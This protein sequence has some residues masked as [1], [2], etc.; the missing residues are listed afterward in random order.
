MAP[1]PS[2]TRKSERLE[3][4]TPTTPAV[5]R[6]SGS[7][8]KQSMSSLLRRSKRGKNQSST[9]SFG[10]KKSGKSLGS[11]VMKKK[12]RKEKS[13]KLLTLETNE[14]GHSEK[15]IIKAVQV[16]TK[17]TDAR[18]YR[19]L[20]KQQQKKA[21]LE[22]FCE[23][24]KNKKAKSSQGYCSNLRAGASENIDGGGDCSQRELSAGG[25]PE[26][27]NNHLD[28][29][30]YLLECWHRGENAVL[31]DDQEQIAKVIYFILSISSNATW[32]FLIIT[33]S[34]ALHSWEE[35]LFRLAPSLYAVVYHGNKDIRKSIRTLEFY[36]EG[37]CI[38]FQILIT[39]PEVIIEDL[40]MLESMKWEAIIVDE[41]QRSRIYSHFKQIKLLSTAMR[42]LLVNGQL[43]VGITEHLLSLLVHQSDPDGSECL[44]IDSSHKTGIFKERLSQYIANGCK[45]DSSR[46]KEYWVPVQ[47][48]IMQLEQYCAI[49]L[50]N[51]LL[52]CSSSKNDLAG[53]LHDIL[54]SAR[55]CCDHPYIMDPSLQISLTKDSKEADI[56]DIGIKASGKLQ[57]LD[58]MLFNIKERGLRVLVL[59]QSSGG[60][61]KDNVGDILDDF[62]SQRFGKGCYELVDGHVLPSR[63]Q[64]A[65]KNFNNLQEGRFV[66]LLETRACSPSIKLSSVDTVII[67]ASDW[68]PHTDIRNLQK[69]TLYSESEQ[70]N[71]FRLYSSCTV[72]ERVLIV[73]RQ[74]KT[75]DRNLQ[76]IN[77]GACHMLLMWGVSYLFD[78][79]SE[80]N[81][82]NDPASSGNMLFEQSHMKDVMQEFLT[83][84]TQKGKDKNLI[85]SIILN[86]KQNQGSYTTNLPLHGEPKIQLLDEELPHVFWERL[87]KGKQPQWKY[88]SGLFQRNRKRVQYFDDIQKN[89][90]VKADEVVKKRKKVAIDNSNSPSLKAAP[91][92]TSGAPVCS[93]SQFMPSSTGCLTTTDANH[94]SNFT[95]L[96]NKLS[97]LPKANAVDYNERMNLH[98]SRKSLHLVLKPEIEKLSEILQLPEDVK[99]MVDQFLEY[100]LNNHHVSREP[101]SVLQAFLISL[102]WT[103][104]SM[105]KYKL[106]RKESLALAEQHLNFRCTKD[107]ADFVYSKL[108]YLKKVFLYHTGNFKLAGSPKAA[109]FSTKDLSTNQ[110]NG[111]PSPSTQSNMQK[112][113][114]EVENLRPSQEFFFDQ[115]LS[116]LGLT[117]KDYSENIEE[118][119]DEQMNKLLQRQREER[120][121][122]K[123]KY[124]EEKAELELIQRTEAAV[125]HLHSNSSMRTD[126]LK[127]LDNVFAKEFKELKRKMEIRLNNVLE[128]Q[129]ATRN[130][131]QER[132]VHWIG[133]KLSGLLNKPLA[134]ESRYDQQNAATLNSCSK[135]QTSERAQSMPD[136]EVLLEALETVSLNE[137]VFSG[138]LS[139]SEPMLDGASSSMLDR[140][141]PL[142]MP[143]SASVS[144]VSE[145]IVYLNASSGEGQ[146]PVTQVAVR[147][148]EAISSSDGPENT[149]HKSSSES[150]NRDALM[151]PDSE[152]PLGV[153][154]IVSSTGGLENAASANPS[155][156]EG[157]TART[158]SCMDGREVLLD[159]PETA[160]LEAEHGNRVMEKDGKSA[161]VS[162][163][164]TEEDQ[165]NG[166]VSMLNQD[167]QSD[168][169]I[170]VNQQN[171]EVLLG[172]PQTNEVGLQDE[173]VPSGVHGTPVE[174]SASNGGENT[175]VYVTAFS[176]GTGVDQLA[177]VLPSG[178]FETATSAE[179]EGSRTQREID[180]IHAVASDTS[181]PAESSRLQDGVAQVCD[182]QIAFQQVDASASQP[183]VVASGQ[184]P[185]DALVTE[186]LLELLLST[187][188]PTPSDSHPATSFAQLSPIDSIAVGGSGMHISN[189]RAAPV[190]P[191]ISN[192]PGTTLA[193]RMPVS[194]S[195]EPLQSELDR[196]SKE[197]EEIIKIHEDTKLQLKSDCEKEIVEV[198]AQIHKKHD[199]KLQEIESDFQCKKKEM[200]DN[201]NKVLMNKILAEAFKTKCMDSRAS[202]TLGKQQEITSSAV[203][204]LLRQSQ[205]TAQRP[206]IVASS[207]VSAD[208]H[209]TSPS[210]SP[211]S[212]PLEVVRCSSLLSGTP[213]RPPHIGSISAITNN[214]QLGSGIRA[215]APHLQPFRPSA[216]ISTTGLSSF[217]HGMQSQ[218]VPSTFPTLSEIPSRAP[219]S[220]QQSGPQTTTNCCESMG[221]SPSS[222]HLPGLDSLMDVG[223]QTIATQPCSF[224]PVTNLISNP[225]QL[226][227]PELSMLHSVNSVLTNPASEV[228]VLFI[229][230]LSLRDLCCLLALDRPFKGSETGL[231]VPSFQ[232]WLWS[233]SAYRT[234]SVVGFSIC[235]FK[236]REASLRVPK[237][238]LNFP[239]FVGVLSRIVIVV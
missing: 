156:S 92:G 227:Q 147:V 192:R 115:A 209:Q 58:A 95:H 66:F 165:Q 146:I 21:N 180:S 128:F 46:L 139:A 174:G 135:E 45:P 178:G 14:I 40:N 127:V 34:A 172:V 153:T 8:E 53:S 210:L 224:P 60:S 86:V 54:I 219:A 205:P 77:Q 131:L 157:C 212:P 33:T 13:V 136:G 3:N 168:N 226:T 151:V 179:L 140:E 166:L 220:V 232:S 208:G 29:V 196:L 236:L 38:M 175:G 11:S 214:L 181:H 171:G 183:L 159:V 238:Y 97:L 204:Q 173:E 230:Q 23:E 37:G 30:N 22:G 31:I 231:R 51:S 142:E 133:V 218:Q 200:N 83:I 94:V 106:D 36:S 41:C 93:M 16:E 1:S 198:I 117:Q 191:G 87:L 189:M 193:V 118:K 68:K 126:K 148:L 89:P 206:P 149:I 19:S 49:L 152:F 228:A 113:R 35:G 27:D 74:D 102:C 194:M 80:F 155:P 96:N 101:A 169:I 163:N 137:D 239:F 141:V 88:S 129:L 215:P 177:G 100:V 98:Y 197:T 134:N 47:L 39:S 211:P 85:N 103:A 56:L 67:F 50:S 79:L 203:Q 110:S 164:A 57:L 32:P 18:V 5:M 7:V 69:I 52:L 2:S 112:V 138:V 61:G 72:E 132:K 44:V 99:V 76:R 202:S 195:Q 73:A 233:S 184:S 62:I 63:K 223:Y 122:L 201:Q 187:G 123:K 222:T 10:S 24:T 167:S 42:L 104:A 216:S 207:G 55:K 12:H 229:V 144:N 119:C 20:F 108:R 161:M 143:Q 107:E 26:F 162:D 6:K 130:K 48:S 111:R 125:I 91:I 71:I 109:E 217:L 15:H 199:I 65:L 124:E 158:T 90:E 188:S 64:A 121:E 28:F 120:E 145:N 43:K 185:N 81:C 234:C 4:R 17:I 186:H 70:I 176:N 225:N 160:S 221:A 235:P 213:T 116:H 182:N 75:L 170:A 82:G 84:V 190:T 59:F 150:P 154:E 114:I 25:S 9:S 105:I 237:L 78:K